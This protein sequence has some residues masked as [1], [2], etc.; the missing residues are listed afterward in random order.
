LEAATPSHFLC[1][2][3]DDVARGG[4]DAEDPA[5]LGPAAPAKSSS[6]DDRVR[7]DRWRILRDEDRGTVDALDAFVV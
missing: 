3:D 4:D 7:G 5:S 1:D 6:K 2:N